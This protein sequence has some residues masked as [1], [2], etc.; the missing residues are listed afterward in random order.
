MNQD[1][2]Y[3][4][5]EGAKGITPTEGIT[6]TIIARCSGDAPLVLDRCKEVLSLVL[7]PDSEEWP[8]NAEWRRLLP[9]WFV[10]KSAAEISHQEAERRL[11]LPLSERIRLSQQWS[12][13]AFVHWFQPNERHWIWWDAEVKDINTLQIKV[14]AKDVPFPWAALDWLLRA[15]G[16]L[17]VEEE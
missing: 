4:L 13:S 17:T 7:Q 5:R 15:S 14:I 11:R 2:I 12:I 10:N 1:E 6:F 16:A 8:S 3:R 9:E